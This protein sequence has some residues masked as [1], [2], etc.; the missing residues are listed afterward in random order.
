MLSQ[1]LTDIQMIHTYFTKISLIGSYDSE[2]AKEEAEKNGDDPSKIPFQK[3]MTYVDKVDYM[4]G[5]LRN[6]LDK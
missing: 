5:E 2:R 6:L 3:P 4:K 1:Q